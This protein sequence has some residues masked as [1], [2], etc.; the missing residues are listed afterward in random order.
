MSTAMYRTWLPFLTV[1]CAVVVVLCVAPADG[2]ALQRI[3]NGDA[4]SG[5]EGDPID[6]NDYGGGSGNDD[7]VEDS[8]AIAPIHRLPIIGFGDR[9]LV[10]VPD[11]TFGVRGFTIMIVDR[12]TLAGEA[13]YAP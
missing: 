10:L 6:S 13:P 2:L 7:N 1:F 4:P 9:V 12:A 11:S 8:C 5:A 3:S